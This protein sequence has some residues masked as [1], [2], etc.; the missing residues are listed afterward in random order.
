MAFAAYTH[1]GD[2]DHA[3]GQGGKMIRST[4]V[5]GGLASIA[6]L[7]TGRI[8]AAGTTSSGPTKGQILVE[9]YTRSGAFDTSFGGGDG[10][11]PIGFS[12]G[13]HPRDDI[14][15]DIAVQGDGRIVVVGISIAQTEEFAVVRLNAGGS[16]DTGFHG[17]GVLTAF[18]DDAEAKG[19]AVNNASHKIVVVGTEHTSNPS[20]P[21]DAVLAAR[22]LGS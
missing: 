14:A 12:T 21:I 3:F 4:A 1:S 2:L 10:I 19:V 5:R 20:I 9:K 17:G 13:G 18:D 22:Y 7:G 6:I 8:L 16:L 11:V 15:S